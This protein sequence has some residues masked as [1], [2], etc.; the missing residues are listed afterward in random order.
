VLDLD[1][2]ALHEPGFRPFLI[3]G[4]S[5]GYWTVYDGG[6][7][8]VVVADAYLR[9]LR[10]GCGKALGT[11]RVYAS[12]L[13]V[14]FEFCVATGRSLRGAALE[15][16]R[17]VHFLAVTPIER[18]GRGQ[19]QLRSP[20]R[21]N[22]IL[23]SVREVYREGV[24]RG[25]LD[26][27][28]LCAL[29]RAERGYRL[30]VGIVEDQRMTLHERPRHRLRVSKRGRPGTVSFE[31]FA[32]LMAACC[33]W[34]D[35][36]IIALLGRAGLRRGEAVT[37]WMEDVHLAESSQEVGCAEPGPHLHVRRREDVD[38]GAAKSLDPRVVP[39]DDLV[40]FCLDQYLLERAGVK[41]AAGCDRLLVNLGSD[42]RGRGM[43]PDRLGALFGS[44]SRRAGLDEVVTP[45]RLRHSFASELE[46]SGAGLILIQEL[47]GHRQITSTQVYVQPGAAA[48]RAAVE[49]AYSR[50][51]AIAAA[52]QEGAAG[53]DG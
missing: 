18:R 16:D 30:P 10:F 43:R 45:H 42:Y 52:G 29:F 34:R 8:P 21:V 22:H 26:G 36:S 51:R 3:R 39:A 49:R 25:L 23:S 38:G 14:F 40:V 47:L 11:T 1:L 35:R 27:D 20:E 9:R 5:S 13:A 28:V 24:A 2:G 44:L 50:T 37:L 33:T 48:L 31:Q 41:E 6:Y 19:G 46:A 32:G 53:V 4:E 12:N 17:F 15:F 7:E